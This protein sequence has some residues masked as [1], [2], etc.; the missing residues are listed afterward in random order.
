MAVYATRADVEMILGRVL[1]ASEY[2]HVNSLL[3]LASALI[4][5]ETNQYAFAPGSYTIGRTVRN[6]RVVLPGKI[7]SIDAV[8]RIN[9]LYGTVTNLVAGSNY[10]SH[11]REIFF[12][13]LLSTDSQ[14]HGS[15]ADYLYNKFIFV[16][17]DFTVSVP[18]PD[19]VVSLAAGIVSS[20][21][22]DPMLA[23]AN[24]IAG[25]YPVAK[26]SSSG[27]VWL[28]ASD[29]KILRKYKQLPPALDLIG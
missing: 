2:P 10:N 8:R 17:V 11:G 6:R 16:E 13:S 21:I 5:A 25:S 22:S 12:I 24:A 7:A 28:S 19:E 27:K 23:A 15:E 26:V 29:K 9:K 4:D 14:F 20:V 18:I 1:T 3:N